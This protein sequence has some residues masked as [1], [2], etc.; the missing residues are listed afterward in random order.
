MNVACP[1]LVNS[2]VMSLFPSLKHR[3][4]IALA[5]CFAL[6]NAGCWWSNET[7]FFSNFSIRQLVERSKASAGLTCD[8]A[9]TGGGS[10]IRSGAGGIGG[11]GSFK[12]HKSDSFGCHLKS[13]EAF[14]ETRFLDALKIDVERA[15]HDAGAQIT[16]TGSAGAASFYFAYSL[17]NVR[18]RV[19]I[20]GSRIGTDYYNVNADL[21]E[22]GN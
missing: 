6:L 9:G 7:P 11:G 15:L 1:R 12:F 14:D 22:S 17:K 8:L 20:S 5:V 3:V 2:I 16:E 13:S 18:G 21:D 10:G 19:Q 4:S